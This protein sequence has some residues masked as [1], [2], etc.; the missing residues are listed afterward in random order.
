MKQFAGWDGVAGGS[1]AAIT[2]RAGGALSDLLCI[3][4]IEIATAAATA[5]KRHD[6]QELRP[7]KDENLSHLLVPGYPARTN[8]GPGA[9]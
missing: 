3:A 7:S 8:T 6:G 4:S 1:R 2:H 9:G 5:C